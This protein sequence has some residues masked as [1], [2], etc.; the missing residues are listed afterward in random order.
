MSEQNAWFDRFSVSWFNGVPLLSEVVR[1]K[2]AEP[3]IKI[4]D[5]DSSLNLMW[6]R[7]I[8]STKVHPARDDHA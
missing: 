7:I 5:K 2:G 6:A 8:G 3:Y 1:P 4:H